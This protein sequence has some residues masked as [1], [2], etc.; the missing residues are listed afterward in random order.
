MEEDDF[1]SGNK[2]RE[3]LKLL[4]VTRNVVFPPNTDNT[5]NS[6]CYRKLNKND[7]PNPNTTCLL[8]L[9]FHCLISALERQRLEDF[10]EC[11]TNL[12]HKVSSRSV[13]AKKRDVVLKT[14]EDR[15][16]VVLVS[17]VTIYTGG[18]VCALSSGPGASVPCP[19]PQL[20]SECTCCFASP[21]HELQR[22]TLGTH[23]RLVCDRLSEC[24][25]FLPVSLEHC[26]LSVSFLSVHIFDYPSESLYLTHPIRT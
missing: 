18:L 21:E 26:T 1:Q 6:E 11:K 23:G 15:H 8:D 16:E 13:T 22:R 24:C 19:H 2:H 5:K 12:S 17:D 20:Q 14:K 7:Q 9:G 4:N 3:S 10:Y 25:Y